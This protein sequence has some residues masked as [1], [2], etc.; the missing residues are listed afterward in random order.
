MKT[1]ARVMI[2]IFLAVGIFLAGYM[3]NRQHDPAVS[4]ASDKQ[5]ICYTCPMHPQCKA[6][7]Y[8]FS[9]EMCKRSFEGNPGKYIHKAMEACEMHRAGMPE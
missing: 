9:V 3:A 6:E 8:Y 4:S 1:P 2:G 7:N 5:G